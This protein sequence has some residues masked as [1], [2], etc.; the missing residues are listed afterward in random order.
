MI[1]DNPSEIADINELVVGPGD[2]AI[3]FDNKC[4]RPIDE[5]GCNQWA[6]IVDETGGL[7]R[8]NSK[9][10][11]IPFQELLQMPHLQFRGNPHPDHGERISDFFLNHRRHHD[12]F[13]A[14]EKALLQG[15]LQPFE[16]G[17]IFP[18][19]PEYKN[20]EEFEDAWKQLLI[21]ARPMDVIFTARCKDPVSR[22]IA[23]TTHGPFS[24][25]AS[26]LGN[27]Q[28]SESVTSGI[29]TGQLSDLYKDRSNWVAIYRHVDHLNT[30]F[31]FEEAQKITQGVTLD[32]RDGYN[33]YQAFR[34]GIM[35]FRGKHE[36]SMAPNSWLYRG[37]W[38]N[39]TRIAWIR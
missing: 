1:K 19:R 5:T 31:T 22:I 26:Y 36:E 17:Q 30:M 8:R 18:T 14:G 7:T 37:S 23:R 35:S 28:I 38:T 34:H 32:F 24:H 3:Y 27:G 6:I 15:N 10:V 11:H 9:V 29:R 13:E 16:W 33:W 25:V 12:L 39:C 21:E 20:D 4:L 2:V